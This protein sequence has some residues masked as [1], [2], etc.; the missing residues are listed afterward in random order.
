M[1]F[2]SP[3]GAKHYFAD[4]DPELQKVIGSHLQKAG[5]VTPV[6]ET[7][8]AFLLYVAKERTEGALGVVSFSIR[9]RDYD[10]WINQ[11][12]D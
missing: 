2:R 1:L 7:P 3:T 12:K 11:Q 6:I 5:D 4:L 10:A 9:K 8:D